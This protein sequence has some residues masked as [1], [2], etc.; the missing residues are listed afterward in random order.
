MLR[1]F[2][3]LLA[4]LVLVA[5]PRDRR[6]VVQ[7]PQVV[8][9]LPQDTLDLGTVV[10]ALPPPEPETP[11]GEPAPTRPAAPTIPHAPAPLLEAVRREQSSSQFCYT[12]HGQKLDPSLRGAVTM[13]VTVGANGIS[14]ARV[15]AS[16]WVGSREAGQQ[17]NRCLVDQALRAWTLAPGAVQPGQY[18]VPLQFR[19]G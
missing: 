1:S 5:C 12:E 2:A 11:P 3:L 16:S 6:E 19:G 18:A 14:N 15:G 9:T 17:V 7:D 8:D 10:A 4:L 13:V